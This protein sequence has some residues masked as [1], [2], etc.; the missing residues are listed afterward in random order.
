MSSI[1]PIHQ[2]KRMLS[3]LVKRA[4]EG[5]TI[6]IGTHGR[7][8]AKLV[9]V[10]AVQQPK[11]IIGSMKDILTVPDDFD[12]ALPNDLLDAFEGQGPRNY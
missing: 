9:S 10:D 3:Q 12:S 6:L 5:E 1:I 11:R 7:A 8:S 4:Y 2:A